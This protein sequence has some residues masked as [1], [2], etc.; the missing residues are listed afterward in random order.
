MTDRSWRSRRLLGAAAIGLLA[1]SAVA[2]A[3]C[4]DDDDDGDGGGG[5]TPAAATSPTAASGIDYSTLGGEIRVD[6]S[7]T[8][9]PITEAVAEEFSKVADTRVNVA[10]SGTGGGFEKF[11]RGEIE[12]SDASRPIEDDEVQAC[13]DNGITDIVEIRV[14]TD[15]LSVVVNPANDF[16]TCMTVQQLHDTFKAGGVGQWSEIDPS[17]P[18]EDITFYYPGTDSGT[19]DYFVEEIITGVDEAASHRGDGTASEDDNVLAQGVE[20][21]ENAIGYFGFAYFQE[22]GQ[23]LNAVAVDEGEGCVEPS[24]ATA[25]DGTYAPLSRP[26]FIYT[27][28][29]LLEGKAEV[30]G[31]VNFYLENAENLA[32]EVGYVPVPDDVLAAQVAKIE[33]FL[34]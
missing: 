3:A 5:T 14:A 4:G 12:V 25:L 34:P 9:F 22:A 6:G 7:S 20:N 29:S 30:L 23:T 11:C 21:N 31:F 18:A 16:A 13:A 17:W 28:E 15:A 10:F 27:R 32:T 8:V 33:P 2:F 19:F 24:L 26:L 1:L